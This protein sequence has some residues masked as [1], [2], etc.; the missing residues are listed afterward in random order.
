MPIVGMHDQLIVLAVSSRT[1][2]LRREPCSYRSADDHLVFVR[3]PLT[4][5]P[6]PQFQHLSFQTMA[7]ADEVP[8]LPW[9]M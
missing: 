6:R 9:Q 8:D 3:V 7:A 1:E 4:P 2:N 5:A